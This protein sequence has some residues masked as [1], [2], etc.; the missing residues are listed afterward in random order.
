MHF[1]ARCCLNILAE[2]VVTSAGPKLWPTRALGVVGWSLPIYHSKL[3]LK[4]CQ[5]WI[6][7]DPAATRICIVARNF[8]IFILLC[9]GCEQRNPLRC[10]DHSYRTKRYLGDMLHPRTTPCLHKFTQLSLLFVFAFA[11]DLQAWFYSSPEKLRAFSA[12]WIRIRGGRDGR[13]GWPHFSCT[14]CLYCWC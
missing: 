8:S 2:K 13:N 5:C 4:R 1:H 6:L 12:P 10:Q 9:A 11:V 3:Q 7:C 14:R